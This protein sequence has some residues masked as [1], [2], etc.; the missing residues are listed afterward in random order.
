MEGSDN[1]SNPEGLKLCEMPLVWIVALVR[2]LL[3]ANTWAVKLR[4][5]RPDELPVGFRSG[6]AYQTLTCV[7]VQLSSFSTTR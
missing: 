1:G 4:E 3:L 2:R 7:P 5:M 6:L